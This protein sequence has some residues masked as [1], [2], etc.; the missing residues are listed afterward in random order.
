M[1]GMEQTE[2]IRVS[3]GSAST[4]G[5]AKINIAVQPTTIYLLMYAPGKCKADCSFCPQARNSSSTGNYLS[6]VKWPVYP[7]KEVNRC[8][9]LKRKFYRR[10]CLQTIV[11]NQAEK[12]I[13]RIVSR[14]PRDK[15][16]S[17]ST[18]PL[19]KSK[20]KKLKQLSVDTIGLPLDAATKRIFEKVKRGHS[21][22]EY[23]L[24]MKNAVELFGKGK[25]YTHLIIGLGETDREAVKFMFEMNRLGVKTGLFSFT[26][27]KGTEMQNKPKPSL[28][29]YRKL[30]IINYFIN[31]GH[32]D[33][34]EV[35]FQGDEINKIKLKN[36][37]I[38]KK[39][40]KGGPF[41]TSGC[42]G[43]NRPFYN[44][45]PAGPLYNYPRKPGKDEIKMIMKQIKETV[46]VE[47]TLQPS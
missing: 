3:I 23:L 36:K 27:V 40:L 32:I 15:P 25:V 10:I 35:E 26:P 24:A 42:P 33:D 21:W 30:Q 7:F 4:L 43:C 20:I 18:F 9:K 1:R 46:T 8:L 5:L 41:M 37:E 38:L 11:Y 14:L 47:E 2:K 17:I 12:D 22:E 39:L 34:F 29:R 45:E 31:R 13:L 19:G 44:E 16:L 6:R 28:S